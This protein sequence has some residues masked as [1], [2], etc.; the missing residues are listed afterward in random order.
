M[1]SSAPVIIDNQ[2][3]PEYWFDEGCHITEWL[4]HPSDP[5]LSVARARLTP[6]TGTRWHSLTDTF[7]RYVLLAGSGF[8]E[9]GDNGRQVRGGDV[10]VI[11]AGVRQRIRND[12]TEDLVF[13]A[14]CT[15]RFTP[16][17]YV[18]LESA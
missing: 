7:E 18:D 4:N 16:D 10:V 1:M 8:V 13:L 14:L 15:P 12:G 9:V 17:C 5:A 2:Q 3:T 11:P 6:G